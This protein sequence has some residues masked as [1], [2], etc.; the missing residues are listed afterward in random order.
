M[1]NTLES[2]KK[3][4]INGSLIKSK[5]INDSLQIHKHLFEYTNL[6]KNTD[7]SQIMVD[8]DGVYFY[9]NENNLCLLCPPNE[10]RVAPLEIM[11]FGSYE[12]EESHIID[13]LSENSKSILDI[14][15]NIGFYSTKLAKGNTKAKIYSF[16]PIPE[17]YSY[18][19][20]NISINNIG[21]QVMCYNYGLSDSCGSVEF[22]ISPTNGTNASLVNVAQVENIKK[23][24]GLT[25]T[26]DQWC[27]NYGVIPDFIKCDVEG[28]E[29]LVFKGGYKVLSE[30]HPIV[31]TE[32]LRKW[33]KPFG[34]HPN[35]VLKFFEELG[36]MSF[37]I[38]KKYHLSK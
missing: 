32:L 31:V 24:T 9:I 26:L 38:G 2:L 30:F 36:Y 28:A 15:A 25:I 17:F 37:S 4:F 7:I 19:Q 5:F 16:E 14:G 35:D 1:N 3:L 12:P 11:N 10:A 13:I 18:L 34:Y 6:I 33:A 21:K 20:K 22:F 29:L 23:I 27:D 8:A